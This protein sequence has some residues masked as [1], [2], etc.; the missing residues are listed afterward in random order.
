MKRLLFCATALA[1]L[2][3]AC[4]DDETN[5]TP[6]ST[7]LFLNLVRGTDSIGATYNASNK[8]VTYNLI[9]SREGGH[10][11]YNEAVYENGRIVKLN[12]SEESPTA[13]H[14]DRSYDYN[15]AGNV[16]KIKFHEEDGTVYGFDSLAYDNNGR[17]AALYVAEGTEGN[18]KIYRKY[19]LVWDNKGNIIKQHAIRVESGVETKDSVTTTYTYDDKIN[20]VAKQVEIFLM[21]PEGPAFGLSANNIVTEKTVSSTTT[22]EEYTKEYTYDEDNYPVTM[23]STGKY[24]NGGT[25]NTKVENTK[26]RYIRK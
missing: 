16:V 23:K 18:I 15:A 2:F 21:E 7:K 1:V 5:P 3:V 10:S 26:I 8:I 11:Y 9:D 6:Q 19:A 25:V 20:Y 12:Y 22:T 4:K 17:L 13:L 14:L 24:T